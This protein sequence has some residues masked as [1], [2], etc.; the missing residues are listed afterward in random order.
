M[1]FYFDDYTGPDLKAHAV[2]YQDDLYQIAQYLDLF[3]Q[4]AKMIGLGI[5]PPHCRG[6][7]LVSNGLIFHLDA[8]GGKARWARIRGKYVSIEQGLSAFWYAV[9][10]GCLQ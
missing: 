9:D 4:T 8:R 10:F 7:K 5:Y 2:K 1:D 6:G 3:P